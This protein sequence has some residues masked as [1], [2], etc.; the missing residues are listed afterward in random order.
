MGD[1][2][3]GIGGGEGV[4]EAYQSNQTGEIKVDRYNSTEGGGS[5]CSN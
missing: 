5:S 1:R 2:G 3:E 4:S